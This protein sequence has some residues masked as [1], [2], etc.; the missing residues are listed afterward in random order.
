LALFAGEREPRN[1]ASGGT[2][3]SQSA[4]ALSLFDSELSEVEGEAD[5]A[6]LLS[7]DRLRNRAKDALEVE[8]ENTA[9]PS[10]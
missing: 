9:R 2:R 5:A 3:V 6:L 1:G 8:L 10:L 4:L 7:E